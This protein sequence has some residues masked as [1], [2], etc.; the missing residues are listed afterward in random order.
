MITSEITHKSYE[1]STAIYLTNPIQCQR[2]L[3]YL[4][5]EFLLDIL[6]NG[7]VRENTLVFVWER[8]PETARAKKL[9]DEHKL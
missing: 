5:S 6:W 9:W 3:E 8:C 2:Y 7:N 1:P 4:G